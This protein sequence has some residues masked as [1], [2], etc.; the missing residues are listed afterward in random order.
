MSMMEGGTHCRTLRC[1]LTATCSPPP[2]CITHAEALSSFGF[3]FLTE[4]YLPQKLANKDW[5]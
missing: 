2:L 1:V 4:V 5:I 3:Q